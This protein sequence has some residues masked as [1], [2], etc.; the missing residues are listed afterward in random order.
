MDIFSPILTALRI[1]AE[2]AKQKCVYN[3]GV[4]IS[5]VF[6]L[7]GVWGKLPYPSRWIILLSDRAELTV[8]N[9]INTVNAFD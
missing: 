4:Y 1:Q 8:L 7:Q 9:S 5:G 3:R 6:T 2:K